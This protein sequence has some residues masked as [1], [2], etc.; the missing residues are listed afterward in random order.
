ML[1]LRDGEVLL[2]AWEA[3]RL[4]EILDNVL[5]FESTN[6]LGADSLEFLIDKL[7]FMNED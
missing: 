2:E 3:K 1:K 4:A 6:Y 5:T 7:N